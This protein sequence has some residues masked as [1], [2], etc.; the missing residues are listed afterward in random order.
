[1]LL[2]GIGVVLAIVFALAGLARWR[3]RGRS[4]SDLLP[5]ARPD[6]TENVLRTRSGHPR[7]R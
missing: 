2:V 3:R 7:G 5:D 4:S 1:M 6:L